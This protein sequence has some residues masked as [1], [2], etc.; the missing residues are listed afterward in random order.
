M[1][2]CAVTDRL[3]QMLRDSDSRGAAEYGATVDRTDL[4]PLDWIDHATA[5]N[6]D[7]AKYLQALRRTLENGSAQPAAAQEAVVWQWRCPRADTDW[8][9]CD[10]SLYDEL[11]KA[12][13][14]EAGEM[15]G[16]RYEVR[17]LYAAP[18]APVTAAP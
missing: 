12:I 14:G 8:S 17:A 7:S 2:P 13:G 5:E 3:V 15:N 16:L 6:L 11:R 10:K 9:D 18:V 1:T 4:S